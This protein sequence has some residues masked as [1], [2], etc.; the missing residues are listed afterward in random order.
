MTGLGSS[1]GAC[2]FLR[3]KCTSE[4]V[5]APY[6]SY[7]LAANHFAAVHKVF[8][9]SNVSKLLSNLP[10]HHRSEAAITISYEGLARMRDPVYGCVA[11]IFALQ[12]QVASLQEEIEILGNQMVNLKFDVLPS[13][14][15]QVTNNLY[16]CLQFRSPENALDMDEYL[17]QEIPQLSSTDNE[18]ANQAFYS[19]MNLQLPPVNGLDD[20]TSRSFLDTD[21]EGPSEGLD[22]EIFLLYPWMGSG[23]DY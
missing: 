15:S 13:G 12:Q 7:D 16:N 1:C 21:T 14:S 20:P 22:Q 6:F 5:F 17:N 3:R 18:S 23:C 4:C 11:H 2:K 19:Q 10:L 9:A 8:G